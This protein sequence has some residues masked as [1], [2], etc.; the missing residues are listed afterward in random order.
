MN[1]MVSFSCRQPAAGSRQPENRSRQLATGSRLS[2]TGNRAQPAARQSQPQPA[3]DYRL[4]AAGCELS[5][6]N[7]EHLQRVFFL[8]SAF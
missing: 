3:I 5:I 1:G 7:R 8:Y 2:A 4:S 6:Q